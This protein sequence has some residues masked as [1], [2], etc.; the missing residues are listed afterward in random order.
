MKRNIIIVVC[1]IF[2]LGLSGCNIHTN[3]DG[4]RERNYQGNIETIYFTHGAVFRAYGDVTA[5]KVDLTNNAFYEIA[6]DAEPDVDLWGTPEG[7]ADFVFVSD[8]DDDA[9]DT[10][11]RESARHGLTNWKSSYRD[12]SIMDGSS[13]NIKIV[14]SDR[15]PMESTGL[16]KYPATW[17]KVMEDFKDLTGKNF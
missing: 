13:W 17:D 4:S 12:N 15:D 9:I 8:L 14:F 2:I 5:Y 16:N 11:F 7:D 3:K 1:L 6:P 10:F